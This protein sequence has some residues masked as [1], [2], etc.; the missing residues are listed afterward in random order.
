MVVYC[1]RPSQKDN[2]QISLFFK[3]LTIEAVKILQYY[4]PVTPI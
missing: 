3:R 4:I 1:S 2:T